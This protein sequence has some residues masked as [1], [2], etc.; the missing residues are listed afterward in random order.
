M[1]KTSKRRGLGRGLDALLA[2]GSR[3]QTEAVEPTAELS[4]GDGRLSDIPIEQLERGR[5]QPRRD[6]Q[7]EALHEL[8]SSIR[9]Q[10]VMQPIVVRPVGPDRFEIIA[11]ERRWRASQ[12]AGLDKIPALIRDVPDEA[13]IAMALIENLQR[14]DL[15]PIEEA[16]ALKRLQDEFGLTQQEVADA[17][18]KS[19]AAVANALRLLNLATDVRIMLERGDLEMGHA[20][21]LLPLQEPA[22][23][24]L[25]RKIVARG[26]SVRQAE[27]LVRAATAEAETQAS[28]KSPALSRD[29]LAL[30]EGLSDKIGV[31]VEVQQTAKG[32]G[33]LVLRYTNLDELEGILS[34]LG[35]K[36][37]AL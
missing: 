5:Y 23:S 20:R 21:C 31:P 24:E 6:M 25:A 17:V 13:A 11:G 26:L 34:H 19:R 27:A 33:R 29:L 30:Q 12:L 37:N 1:S 8:A 2:A 15:N 4:P 32:G 7:E 36:P 9:A 3:P 18:G 14:E 10:G 28:T 22:Q 35:Y 16:V